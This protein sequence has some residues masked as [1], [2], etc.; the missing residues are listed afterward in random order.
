MKTHGLVGTKV[1]PLGYMNDLYE[2]VMDADK[3]LTF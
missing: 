1:C 3:V 2:S